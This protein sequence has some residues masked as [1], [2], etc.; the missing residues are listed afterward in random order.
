[1]LRSYLKIAWRSLNKNRLFS[2]INIFGLALSMS[3][4]M[5]VMLRIKDEFRYDLFHPYADRTYRILTNVSN[6]NSDHWIFASSP[7]PLKPLLDQQGSVIQET[8]QLYPAGNTPARYA[9]KE[10]KIKGCFT[11]DGFFRIFGFTLKHG[12]ERTSL[13]LPGSVVL[14]SATAY[15]YFR[16]EDPI[17]KVMGIG[18]MGD[19]IITGV[20]NEEPRKSHIAFDAFVSSA[21]IHQLEKQKLLPAKS[22][23]WN[24]F[25]DAYTYVLL[26]PAVAKRT[27]QNVLAQ[28]NKEI[29]KDAKDGRLEFETQ[30]LTKI[31]PSPDLLNDIGKG[32]TWGKL[33][34][35][36]GIGLI[37]LVSACFN[38]TNLTIARALTRAREVG[39]RK[40]AGAKRFQI[41]LQYM[42]ESVLIAFLSL[43]LASVM[44]SF[45]IRYNLFGDGGDFSPSISSD[46]IVFVSF[47]LFALV[48]GLIAGA[49]PAWILSSFR[50]ANVLKNISTVKLF[51]NLSLQKTLIV[52]QFSLSLVIVIFLFAFYR[53]FNYMAEAD[54]G[55]RKHNILTIPLIGADEKLLRNE[56]SAITGVE[57]IAALSDNFGRYPSGT[58]SAS[59][60]RDEAKPLQLQYYYGDEQ[61]IPVMQLQLKAGSNFPPSTEKEK[62]IILNEQAVTA[63]QLENESSA[64]GKQLWI[65]DSTSLQVIGVLK[66]FH[67]QNLGIPIRPMALRSAT[68]AY[69]YLNVSVKSANNEELLQSVERTWKQL[70]PHEP[71]SYYWLEKHLDELASQKDTISILGYL[72]FIAITLA[73]L[74]LLGLVVYT[75]ETKRKEISVRKIIGA[76]V[77]Q[78]VML[79]SRS[80]IKLLVISGFVAIPVGYLLSFIFLQ[81]F[82][83]RVSFGIGSALACFFFLLLIGLTTIISQTFR[84]STVNPIKNL[85][86]E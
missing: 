44:L 42:V 68:G 11:D 54:H 27:L 84:A 33:L 28:V 83:S 46:Y 6:N 72:A 32:T 12:D 18:N 15:K 65:N 79:L 51:G 78:L 23:S 22:E 80:F 67:H 77:M 59:L 82:A 37:I 34:A 55:F 26:K 56:L 69:S 71:F 85:R 29:N 2:F 70:H 3:V 62:Y 14:S 30:S 53:Q 20:M 43:L 74:G 66:N 35:L 24:T 63:L 60:D 9:K 36:V 50:P 76:E 86:V 49:A 13:S 45:I 81:N 64:I 58:V 39:I 52:F 1:M 38:Y 40:V 75:I 57:N 25:Q 7:L 4:C 21:S 48:S 10:L 19:F 5:I 31:T 61:L 47:V 16:N 73:S 17:G 41:F 8:V